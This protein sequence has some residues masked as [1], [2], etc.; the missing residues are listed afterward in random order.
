MASIDELQTN[1]NFTTAK[2]GADRTVTFLPDPPRAE[3]YYT[4][5]SVDD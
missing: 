1:L 2:T 4:V 3:R 5:I